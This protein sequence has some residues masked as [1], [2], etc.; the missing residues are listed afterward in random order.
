LNEYLSNKI[1]KQYKGLS[2]EEIKRKVK[3]KILETYLNYVFF[4]NHAY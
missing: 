1:K 3:E 4:G 2:D